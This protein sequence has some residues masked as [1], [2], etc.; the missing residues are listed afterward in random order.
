MNEVRCVLEARAQ[1]GESPVWSI[2]EQVLYWV[3]ILEPAIHRFDPVSGER[4]HWPMPAQIGSM[5]LRQAGGA[6]LALRNG[7][8]LFDFESGK[9]T[10]LTNPETDI[11]TNR[12]NDGK[13]SPD[14]RFWAGTMDD[15]RD[16]Q[17]VAALYRLD[18]NSSCHRMLSGIAVSNGLAWSPDGRTM[19]HSDSYQQVIHAYDYN[20]ATG[21]IDNRRELARPS[22]AIG[23]PDGA[24]VDVEGYYWS[25]G[26]SAGVLNRWAPDGR[27]DRQITLPCTSPTMPCFGGPDL[28]TIY[29]TSLTTGQSADRLARKPLSGGIFAVKVD[30]PGVAVGLFKG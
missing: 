6:V 29:V 24:A 12:F 18:P 15:R 13:V 27:L 23:K 16:R 11:L 1:L 19:Y 7:F 17:P 22:K 2:R 30:V 26:I 28:R 8:H 9:L 5:G 3:D 20:P 10:F 4:W 21:T 25:A 14:G